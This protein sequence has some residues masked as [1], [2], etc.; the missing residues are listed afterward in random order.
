VWHQLESGRVVHRFEGVVLA[1]TLAL[2]PVLVIEADATSSAWQDFAATMNWIIWAIFLAELVFILT[3]APRKAA[4]LRAHWLDVTIVVMTAPLFGRFLSSLRLVRLARLLRLMRLSA[5]LTRIL[6]RERSLTSGDAFRFAALATVL[7][8][9]VSGAVESLVER[10][11]FDSTF[12]G[13]WFKLV[14]VSDS[15]D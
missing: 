11:D 3:V 4:A 6:Q 7:I 9:V 2:I 12:V 13:I 10:G 15:W 8:V 14:S 1:A 5:V